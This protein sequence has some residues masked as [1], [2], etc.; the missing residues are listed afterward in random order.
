MKII[1]SDLQHLPR[2]E[3]PQKGS[4]GIR[5]W[6]QNPD[7]PGELVWGCEDQEHETP[8]APPLCHL[9]AP[10]HKRLQ[11]TSN[12][13]FLQTLKQ[14]RWETS[15]YI[16]CEEQ[17]NV[18][19]IQTKLN[20]TKEPKENIFN[21]TF[22][23]G[24]CVQLLTFLWFHSFVWLPIYL[25]TKVNV[26][27]L[28]AATTHGQEHPFPPGGS[29]EGTRTSTLL[30]VNPCLL[31]LLEGLAHTAR[32]YFIFISPKIFLSWSSLCPGSGCFELQR[33]CFTISCC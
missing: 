6:R 4:A 23:C 18:P 30:Q 3:P 32:I 14:K 2:A 22:T 27:W 28:R 25:Q 24:F 7:H 15:P 5:K 11:G 33:W 21:S 16:S 31:W 10:V 13:L 29:W 1:S 17:S 9:S 19:C 20:K 26:H 12:E 8:L